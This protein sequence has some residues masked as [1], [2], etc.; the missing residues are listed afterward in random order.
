M[1]WELIKHVHTGL[2]MTSNVTFKDE[3]SGVL[4]LGFPRL[5]AI[6]NAVPN[7]T[8]MVLVLVVDV[9]FAHF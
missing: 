8:G 9:G 5:S 2:A 6:Y 1:I 4:G 3:V 7:G